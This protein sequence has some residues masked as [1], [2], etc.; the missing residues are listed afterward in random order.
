MGPTMNTLQLSQGVQNVPTFDWRLGRKSRFFQK[1]ILCDRDKDQSVL[2][3]IVL[4]VVAC[5][6]ERHHKPYVMHIT[7]VTILSAA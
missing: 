5:H 7:N 1:A 6:S 4:L 2:K 3:D